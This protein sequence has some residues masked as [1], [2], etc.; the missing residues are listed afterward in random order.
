MINLESLVDFG[1]ETIAE[2]TTTADSYNVYY[3]IVPYGCDDIF[4]ALEETLH[5]IIDAGGSDEDLRGIM[6]AEKMDPDKSNQEEMEDFIS[7][8]LGYYICGQMMLFRILD[9]VSEY[10]SYCMRWYADH[11]IKME[12]ILEN[13]D[14][15]ESR[16]IYEQIA[17][18]IKE[19]TGEI[20]LDLIGYDGTRGRMDRQIR[21]KTPHG[22]IRA[23]S[24]NDMEYPGIEL[25]LETNGN[26]EPGA[27]MEYSPVKG[28]VILRVYGMN[29]PDGDPIEIFSM[30]KTSDLRNQMIQEGGR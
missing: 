9:N 26:G 5:R 23:S 18:Y 19:K 3:C 12:D 17:R 8:D 14:P 20:P 15:N 28:C 13:I 30:S 21:V 25:S 7:I 16:G 6:C 11:G 27:I 4:A 2:Y 24:M 1:E 22:V 10:H 29:D